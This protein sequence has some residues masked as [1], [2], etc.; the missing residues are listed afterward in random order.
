MG[1]DRKYLVSALGFAV[2]GMILGI[3]MAASHDH[4]QH[5]TH[6]HLLLVGF[7][8]SMM[9]G[10]IHK[11]WLPAQ[12]GVI[13]RAQ[14]ILHHL[15]VVGM[16]SGLYMLFANIV[17]EETLAP[18]LSASSLAVLVGMLLMLFMVIKS[19]PSKS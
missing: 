3:V 1:F 4:V 6:A 12:T 16:I 15:G 2:L 9:Y 17:P 18:V 10:I 8:V 14:F 13:A 5:V 11:L 19:A 7:V